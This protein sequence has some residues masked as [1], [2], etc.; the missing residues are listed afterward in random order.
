[1]TIHPAELAEVSAALREANLTFARRHPGDGGAAQPVHTFI[2]GAQH[3]T[4]D[5]AAR[6]G[7]Q[8]LA[9]LDTYAPDA[10][11]LGAAIGIASHPAL[12]LIAQRVRE[13]LAR[14]PI[15]DYRIDFEDGFGVRSDADEDAHVDAVA[16]EIARGGRDGSLP[17]AHWRTHQ[18]A[19]G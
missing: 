19:D 11:T 9:A 18:A 17:P 3:F 14:E 10:A 15:E 2:E 8:A 5:V 4:A 6:R 12:E 1:M 7:A 16:G 13:K